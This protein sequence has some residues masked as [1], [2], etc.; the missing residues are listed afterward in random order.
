MPLDIDNINRETNVSE[1]EELRIRQKQ[2]LHKISAEELRSGPQGANIRVQ[3]IDDFAPNVAQAC[4]WVIPPAIKN[5]W[6][7]SSQAY[8]SDMIGNAMDTWVTN[9]NETW[10]HADG[11]ERPDDTPDS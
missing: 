6:Q 11:T 5:F 8:I 9:D 10:R 2:R 7:A 3:S 1:D 4:Q